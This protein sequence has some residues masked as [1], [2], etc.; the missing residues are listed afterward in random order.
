MAVRLYLLQPLLNNHPLPKMESVILRVRSVW[1]YPVSFLSE[2][3]LLLFL[4]N[5]G[6]ASNIKVILVRPKGRG[7]KWMV[8]FM[9]YDLLKVR[10][11]GSIITSF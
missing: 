4:L 3:F 8:P 6:E 1:H 10:D 9:R 11:L 7:T 2:L 5:W